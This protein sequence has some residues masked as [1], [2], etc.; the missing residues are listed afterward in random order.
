MAVKVYEKI[1]GM[2]GFCI[3]CDALVVLDSTKLEHKCEVK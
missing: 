3:D 1:K 2:I